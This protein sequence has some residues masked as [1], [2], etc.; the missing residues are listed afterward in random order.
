MTTFRA[1]AVPF[2]L[3]RRP[4]GS[5]ASYP[6]RRVTNLSSPGF[7]CPRKPT[8]G[9]AYT[10]SVSYHSIMQFVMLSDETSDEQSI[11]RSNGVS[12]YVH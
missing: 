5:M 9:M 3:T 12:Q 7:P 4:R 8:R 10:N 1:I 2:T 11:S 6:S